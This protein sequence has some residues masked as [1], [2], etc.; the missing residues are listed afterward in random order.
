MT[1]PVEVR[2]NFCGT[3]VSIAQL[4][5]A[6]AGDISFLGNAKYARLVPTSSASV[7]FLPRNYCGEPSP[8]AAYLIV[9]DPSL[10]IDALCKY[11][12][13][14]L[15]SDVS[16]SMAGPSA[17][18]PSAKIHSTASVG[19]FCAIG[20]SVSIGP[21]CSIGSHCSIGPRCSLGEDVI[22]H[23]RVTLY[24]DCAIGNRCIIHSG[25]VIG[26]D[27]YGYSS[28]P[29]GHKKLT[30]VGKVVLGDDVEIG[31]N[32]TIDRAR[33]AETSI[34]S[35]TKL[36]NLIQIGHNVS[37]GK[38]CLLVAQCGIAG[39]TA[40]GDGVILAGQSGVAGHIKIGSGAMVAAQCGVASDLEPN[41]AVRGTPSMALG[42]ANRFYVLRERMPELFRRVD[43][44]E[45]QL[46]QNLNG[47]G[48]SD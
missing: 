30:H 14:S 44:I 27:G 42:K 13:Q 40:L 41:S 43:R 33:F 21:R 31:A 46:G 17:I 1:C 6:E 36:D 18:S 32:S 37:V 7:I 2:G 15:V 34:G 5:L 23:A 29:N 8:G 39:S 35:G 19:P 11:I 47:G 25:A 24:R 9:D 20:D 16:D 12:E 48:T 38:N 26:C 3:L 45:E 22:L 4:D 10:A 28:G